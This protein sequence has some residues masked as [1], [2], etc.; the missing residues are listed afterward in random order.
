MIL[1]INDQGEKRE[2]PDDLCI[3]PALRVLFEDL[4]EG[5][6]F[7]EIERDKCPRPRG[8]RVM[9]RRRYCVKIVD[10]D[11]DLAPPPSHSPVQC[12]L[13]RHDRED[14]LIIK[15]DVP[16]DRG[17]KAGP[18][19][20]QFRVDGELY[21]GWFY[22]IL[23]EAGLDPEKSPH[24]TGSA[25]N[26][27][28]IGAVGEELDVYVVLLDPFDL[29]TDHRDTLE[30]RLLVGPG[31]PFEILVGKADDC[32]VTPSSPLRQGHGPGCF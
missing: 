21:P 4:I 18:D 2:V 24:R 23:R 30:D 20:S 6:L 5:E 3:V 19:V 26:R 14:R 1:V 13:E 27:E 28:E 22:R 16:D 7:R 25:F 15:G 8:S 17:T 12:F 32:H 10:A 9:E 31:E 11:G 29:G